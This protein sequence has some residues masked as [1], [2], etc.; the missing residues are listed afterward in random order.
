MYRFCS[1]WLYTLANVDKLKK[2]FVF[3]QIIK[4]VSQSSKIF[5]PYNFTL[6]NTTLNVCFAKYWSTHS[7]WFKQNQELNEVMYYTLDEHVRVNTTVKVSMPDTYHT[8]P[9]WSIIYWSLNRNWKFRRFNRNR[10]TREKIFYSKLFQRTVSNFFD[11]LHISVSEYSL[12]TSR[13][14][15][16]HAFISLIASLFG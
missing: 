16:R 4:R 10:D 6:K 5:R 2:D 3:K 11:Y 7:K 15:K 12:A 13:G 8:A 1:K 9:V 14:L